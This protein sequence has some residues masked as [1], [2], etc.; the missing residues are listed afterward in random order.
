M[1]LFIE[2]MPFVVVAALA[3]PFAIKGPN[4]TSLMSLDKLRIPAVS[5]PDFSKA[6]EG[7]KT[8]TGEAEGE[9][10]KAVEVFKWRDE[11]GVW[12]FSDKLEQGRSAQKL[13]VDSNAGVVHFS[14]AGNSREEAPE[15]QGRRRRT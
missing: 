6:T 1:K 11:K 15:I 4:G 7:L 2:V 12:H 13:S 9:P 8:G 14:G 3:A 5:L 10:A